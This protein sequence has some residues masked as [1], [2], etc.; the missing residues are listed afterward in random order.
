[1]A[2]SRSKPK[3]SEDS[4]TILAYRLVAP[5]W[6]ASALS[7]EGARLNGGRWNSP[8]MPMVYLSGSRALAALELLVHLTTPETR[9]IPRVLI[10]V[11]IPRALI[12]GRLWTAP[13]WQEEP[14]GK[15]STDQVDDWLR[16]AST[17]G[18]RAPSV[19]VPE[20][21]NILLNPSHPDFSRINV[22]ESR[23]FSY[24]P[25]FARISSALS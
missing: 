5:K 23:E 6:A 2:F 9:L 20:E 24:D 4:E 18:V 16:T 12:G 15:N 22:L 21:D 10:T 13:G 11:A 3:T 19:L 14:P 1:M 7:G 8:G 17:A 25:R